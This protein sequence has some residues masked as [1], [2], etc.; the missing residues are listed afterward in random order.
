MKIEI[1]LEDPKF[2]DG[3]PCIGWT[4]IG[5]ELWCEIDGGMEADNKSIDKII[6]PQECIDR[7]GE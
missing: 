2:C 5:S 3:C 4:D 6:R 1:N 7:Y